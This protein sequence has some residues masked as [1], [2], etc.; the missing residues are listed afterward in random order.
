MLE[1]FF[2]E[3]LQV[4]RQGFKDVVGAIENISLP[5]PD[6]PNGENGGSGETPQ[7]PE[8]RFIYEG[9]LQVKMLPVHVKNNG[10]AEPGYNENAVVRVQPGWVLN[11]LTYGD[12]LADSG[13]DEMA[14]TVNKKDWYYFETTAL[15]LRGFINIHA[16]EG[17]K[18]MHVK[19]GQYL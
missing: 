10:K 15:R 17:S 4:L 9:T 13:A 1:Q 8:N 14:N 12:A 16:K 6:S 11:M 7:I 19:T 2:S 18:F 5:N 3:I